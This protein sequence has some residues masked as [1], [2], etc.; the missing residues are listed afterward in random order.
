MHVAVDHDCRSLGCVVVTGIVGC[1]GS[2]RGE[3]SSWL[4][5]WRPQVCK[6]RGRE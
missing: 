1:V 2:L 6:V 5:G 3:A 4:E